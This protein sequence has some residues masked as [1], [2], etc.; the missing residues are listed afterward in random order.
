MRLWHGT[1]ESAA[2]SILRAGLRPRGRNGKSNWEVESRAD[3]VYMSTTY[4]PYFA[5]MAT[6]EG[7]RMALVEAE[8]DPEVLLPDEDFL[9]QTSRRYEVPGCEARGIEARTRWFREHLEDFRHHAS[10]SLDRLGN[11]ALHGVEPKDI[12]RVVLVD[13]ERCRRLAWM[14]IDAQVSLIAYKLTGDKYRGL[15]RAF[16]GRAVAL[17][18]VLGRLG[19]LGLPDAQRA[20]LQADLDALPKALEVLKG[21]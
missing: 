2:R 8:V 6:P 17:E 7:E 20:Q 13:I 9:E 15:T 11:A 14:A 16:T 12:R 18:G 10:D 19:A 5:F 3:L 21:A 1:S 4:A